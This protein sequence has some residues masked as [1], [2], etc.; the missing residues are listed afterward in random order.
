MSTESEASSNERPA[1]NNLASIRLARGIAQGDLA[2][3]CGISRQFLSLLESGRTAPNVRVALKL[4]HELVCTVEDLFAADADAAAD[5]VP[6]TFGSG[7]VS[8]GSRVNLI[9]V[10]DR[11]IAHASD[12]P[13]SL[14]AGFENSDGLLVRSGR[15][16]AVR[17]HRS[18]RGMRQNIAVAGC[19]PA[20]SLLQ[21]DASTAK[22][23]RIFWINCG[24]ARALKLLAAGAVHA[25]GLHYSGRD[26]ESNLRQVR[27]L[28]RE[29][30]WLVIHFTR[31][32]NGWMVRPEA[33]AAFSGTQDITARGI[34]LANREPGSGNRHWLD[35]ELA[36]LGVASSSVRG[37][38][39]EFTS[40][41]ACARALSEGRADVA[42]G[43]RAMAHT[44]GLHFIP[45]EQVCF[46]LV[47]PKIHLDLP[48]VR[49]LLDRLTAGEFR[50]EVEAIVGY[51]A[52]MS[53]KRLT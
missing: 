16:P 33:G 18:E 38:Q 41:W 26:D 39:D 46:D 25:A 30:R 21:S 8:E 29:G 20:L 14:G 47:V 10:G 6:V 42:V 5:A 37:Y 43:P 32:D 51:S 40:H 27:R 3:R 12:S 52:A 35:G 2:A 50:R 49:E 1:N 53:G 23:G 36:R 34:R 19:D 7:P 4:A 11:W 24:S 9:H 44:F 22:A 31:W 48:R 28:D 45:S 15:T 17:Y 13:Q